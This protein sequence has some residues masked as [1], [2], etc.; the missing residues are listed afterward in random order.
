M[1]LYLKVVSFTFLF[2]KKKK[3]TERLNQHLDG[4]KCRDLF[5]FFSFDFTG[6]GYVVEM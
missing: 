6:L 4:S 2:F 3:W 5:F 1:F